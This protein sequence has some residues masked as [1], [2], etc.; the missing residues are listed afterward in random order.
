MVEVSG[1]Y[2]AKLKTAFTGYD[3]YIIFTVREDSRASD[4][5]FKTSDATWQAYNPWGGN[6]VYPYPI[7]SSCS[8][9]ICAQS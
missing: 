2:V 6:S 1:V 7:Q 4:L 9:T 3:S 5:Y 8:N